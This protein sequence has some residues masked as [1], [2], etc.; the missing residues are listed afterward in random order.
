MPE[1]EAKKLKGTHWTTTITFEN[2][3]FVSDSKCQEK[4]E[5]N[6]I[7]N[8]VEGVEKEFDHPMVGGKAKVGISPNRSYCIDLNEHLFQC[9]FHKTGDSTYTSKVISPTFGETV[10]DET[11]TEEGLSIT[12]KSS[13]KGASLTEFWQRVP[14]ENGWFKVFK[15]ENSEA[16]CKAVGKK[17]SVQQS[18]CTYAYA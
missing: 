13:S 1:D 17:I 7:D 8:F 14:D 15:T 10:T 18:A 6:V 4:P 16:Y 12:V 5:M 2:G 3:A 11:F 9:I